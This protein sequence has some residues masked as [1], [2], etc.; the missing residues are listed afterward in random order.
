MKRITYSLI[1]LCFLLVLTNGHQAKAATPDEWIQNDANVSKEVYDLLLERAG[2][3][4]YIGTNTPI[5]ME[6]QNVSTF[7]MEEKQ[8][9]YFI[10]RFN[11]DSTKV[12]VTK[13]GV[14]VAYSPKDVAHGIH[15]EDIHTA[16]VQKAVKIFVGPTIA[17]VNY[18]NFSSLNSNKAINLYESSKTNLKTPADASVQAVA[19]TYITN[20]GFIPGFYSTVLSGS[21]QSNK[22]H[23]LSQYGA[24]IDG[25]LVF[26]NSTDS[27]SIF[28]SAN[29]PISVDTTNYRAYTLVNKFKVIGTLPPNPEV[30]TLS[31]IELVV[32]DTDMKPNTAQTVNTVA[33]YTNGTKR[34]LNASEVSWTSSR[35]AVATIRNGAINALTTGEAVVFANYNGKTTFFT[36]KVHN[37]QELKKKYNVSVK[38]P[39]K[40]TLSKP[41][42]TNSVTSSNVYVVDSEGKMVPVIHNVS[43]KT[44]TVTPMYS[45]QS[46]ESYT[47]WVRDIKS[48]TNVLIKQQTKMEFTVQ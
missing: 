12:L 7:I 16:D 38:K 47:V 44:I 20:Y 37:Y 9:N 35:P 25:I 48:S 40:I 18:L 13:E 3:A 46:G 5:S 43:G 4:A 11:N 33:T 24:V 23:V 32:A 45:Y 19:Y 30:N 34:I 10:G 17:E 6:P 36:L 8:A 39:W 2:F 27:M 29:S 22:T 31:S 28:Y 14:I 41:I 42:N 1:M 21:I 15:P 26:N